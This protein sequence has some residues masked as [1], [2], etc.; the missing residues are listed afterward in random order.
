MHVKALLAISLLSGLATGL[1]TARSTN[2]GP[3]E[4]FARRDD[5]DIHLAKISAAKSSLFL[6]LPKQDASCD[7]KSD[8]FAT[9]SLTK[10]GELYLYSTGNPRQQVY[11]DRQGKVGYITGAQSPPKDAQLKGW[12]IDW[13]GDLW[14]ERS[15]LVAC[16]KS[17]DGGGGWSIWLRANFPTPA[18][19]KGCIGFSPRT[20]KVKKPNSCHY[21][22]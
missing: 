9:F 3:F 8:G 14:F 21:T 17:I 20:A 2:L 6:K 11:I 19:N 5:S 12:L 18:G 1:P 4:I 16:P 13:R 15:N 10:N 22:S 7:R